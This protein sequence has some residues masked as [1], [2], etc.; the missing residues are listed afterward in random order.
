MAL[1]LNFAC[2]NYDRMDALKSGEV[3]PEGIDL[4]F[5]GIDAPREIFD[6]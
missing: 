6:R 5:V 4:E 2:G 3:A 1:K